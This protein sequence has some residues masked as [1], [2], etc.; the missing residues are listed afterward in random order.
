MNKTFSCHLGTCFSSSL[1]Y[2][3][4]ALNLKNF[5]IFRLN[6]KKK[7]LRDMVVQFK[8]GNSLPLTLLL[9]FISGAFLSIYK[10]GFQIANSFDIAWLL[11]K[12]DAATHFLSWHFFK[13]EPWTFPPGIVKGYFYP[14]GT[15]IGFTDS[16]PLLAFFFKLIRSFLPANFQ[17]FG[18]WVIC[19]YGLQAVFGYLLMRLLSNKKIVLLAGTLFFLFSPIVFVRGDDHIALTAHWLILAS[20]WLYFKPVDRGQVAGVNRAWLII[21][22]IA[23]LVH[24]YLA[25]MV[26]GLAVAGL[27]KQKIQNKQTFIQVGCYIT[28]FMCMTILMWYLIGFF[29]FPSIEDYAGHGLGKFS[30]NLH[31]LVNPMNTSSIF[32]SFPVVSHSQWEGYS[33]LGAGMLVMGVLC[34]I[35]WAVERKRIIVHLSI[36]HDWPILVLLGIFFMLALS[37]NIS[38]GSSFVFSYQLPDILAKVF[39]VFQSSGRFVWPIYYFLFFLIINFTVNNLRGRIVPYVL[40]LA[41]SIQVY[42]LTPILKCQLSRHLDFE[43]RLKSI[44]WQDAIKISK[45]IITVPPFKKSLIHKDDYIDFSLLVAQHGGSLSTGYLARVSEEMKINA[46]EKI[47][48][49]LMSEEL[50]ETTLY[51]FD[52]KSYMQYSPYLKKVSNCMVVDGYNVCF[53]Q[54]KRYDM[55]RIL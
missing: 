30:M 10:F 6:T 48:N 5:A 55:P 37:P 42:D 49:E 16:I 12:S 38:I 43:T 24:P 21:V 27:I 35:L 40:L 39:N 9:V 47:S 18:L 29:Q 14:I 22:L 25:V 53:S 54:N 15:S 31:S 34:C 8:R 13:N 26:L 45:N 19:S 28:C 1:E 33:Y 2:R 36:D 32:G 50:G 11:T 3:C 23:A 41:A 17:Y 51:I 4:G 44:F 46:W 20:L 7:K 52:K